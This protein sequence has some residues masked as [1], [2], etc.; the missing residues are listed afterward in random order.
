M[1]RVDD[2]AV[3]RVLRE[4]DLGPGEPELIA[5][6]NRGG[7]SGACLWRVRTPYCD[8]CLRAWPEQTSTAQLLIIHDA[9]HLARSSGLE[10]VPEISSTRSSDTFV[11]S[12]LRLWDLST[13]MPGRANFHDR[14]S[15]IRLREACSALA[16]LHNAW[17]KKGIYHALC[18]AVT[19]R[20]DGYKQWNQLADLSWPLESDRARHVVQRWMPAVPE[21]LARWRDATLPTQLCLC[22]IWHDHLLFEEEKLT[23]IL[24]YGEVKLDHVAVDVARMLGSLIGDNETGWKTGLDAYRV[25]RSFSRAE[26]ELAHVL[27]RTGTLLGAANWLRWLHV[28]KRSFDD[29]NAAKA[30]LLTLVERMERWQNPPLHGLIR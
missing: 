19:R 23:A 17:E 14:P 6:G 4:Y 15:E 9:M 1:S 8:L 12:V 27:D 29:I 2:L 11:A 13:W 20:L 22:D 30:R 24:D 10:I 18:P 7:F 28:E 5:L 21:A 3:W 26:E 25:V 16:V